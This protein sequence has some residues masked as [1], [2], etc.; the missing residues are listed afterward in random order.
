MCCSRRQVKN[1]VLFRFTLTFRVRYIAKPGEWLIENRG[2]ITDVSGVVGMSVFVALA[3]V[4]AIDK[5]L[6]SF[7]QGSQRTWETA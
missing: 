7:S 3:G 6:D 1:Y 4:P 5:Q 2:E